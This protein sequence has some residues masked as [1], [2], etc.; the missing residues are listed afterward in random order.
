MTL[1]TLGIAALAFGAALAVSPVQ[2]QYASGPSWAQDPNAGMQQPQVNT[3]MWQGT[4]EPQDF[5]TQRLAPQSL[6]EQHYRAQ[7]DIGNSLGVAPLGGGGSDYRNMPTTG[8]RDHTT[9]W[10]GMPTWNTDDNG[11]GFAAEYE[12]SSE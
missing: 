9:I 7:R 6:R 3:G 10:D 2:A 4:R 12:F 1:R 5:G 11:P 8:G